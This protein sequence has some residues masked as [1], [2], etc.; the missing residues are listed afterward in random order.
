M[1]GEHKGGASFTYTER[2]SKG[3]HKHVAFGCMNASIKHCCWFILHI[4]K[5][6]A[7]FLLSG[8]CASVS[9]R[10]WPAREPGGLMVGP[11]SR[12]DRVEE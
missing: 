10:E 11:R 7:V 5:T 3:Q 6:N 9:S 4:A 2:Y 8:H 12:D 1:S